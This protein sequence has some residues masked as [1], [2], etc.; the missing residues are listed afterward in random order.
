[1]QPLTTPHAR[2]GSYFDATLRRLFRLVAEG[3]GL[4]GPTQHALGSGGSTVAGARETFA[5]APLD[6]RLFDDSTLPLLGKVRFPNHHLADHH[7][8]HV[9]HPGP[10]QGAPQRPGQLPAAVHQPVGRGV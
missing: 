1:M 7:P 8:P 6:S 10:G 3:T 4:G 5:L 9:A 2:E